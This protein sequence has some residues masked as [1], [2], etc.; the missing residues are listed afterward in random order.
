VK[1]IVMLSVTGVAC[2][3][4]ATKITRMWCV[5]GIQMG[6]LNGSQ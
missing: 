4:F 6:N 3:L 2:A 1:R 5:G